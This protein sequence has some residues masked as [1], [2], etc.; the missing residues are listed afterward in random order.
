MLHIIMFLLSKKSTDLKKFWREEITAKNK[1][2]LFRL[3]LAHK[4][5][6]RHFLL[7]WRLASQMY[8]HGN[9]QQRRVAKKINW[10]LQCRYASDVALKATI[11]LNPKF[12]HLTG[13]VIS[14]KS[15]IGDNAV[16][17]QNVTIGLRKE[18]DPAAATIGNNVNIGAGVCILGK[19]N[20][21]HNV[22][23]G[24]MSLVFSDI[25]DDVT[26]ICKTEPVIMI[27]SKKEI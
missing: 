1:L 18:D 26:Y 11:G 27:R 5:R 6:N 25:P 3:W 15:I 16:I 9:K 13:V 7:W 2:S 19:V 8:L 23:I 4:D 17:Y 21:G 12:V 14:G 20:I 24:A 10:S 22:N